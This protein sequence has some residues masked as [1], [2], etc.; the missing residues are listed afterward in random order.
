MV[1]YGYLVISTQL[2]DYAVQIML[3]MTSRNLILKV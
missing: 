2:L 3:R 1:I